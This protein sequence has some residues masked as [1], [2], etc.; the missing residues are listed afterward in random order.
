MPSPIAPPSSPCLPTDAADGAPPPEGL[1]RAAERALGGAAGWTP[2]RGGRSNRLWRVRAPG[3][4]AVVKLY[5]GAP[6]PLFE[7]D[8]AKERAALDALS[9]TGLAPRALASLRTAAGPALIY[10]HVVSGG[11]PPEAEALLRALRAV[12]AV[13]PP[14]GLR[15]AVSGSAALRA[16]LARL[17]AEGAVPPALRRLAARAPDLPPVAAPLFLHGDPTPA[18]ALA[19][20]TGVCLIDWQ[21]PALGDPTDDIALALSP[22][23]R[24]LA[25]LAPLGRAER[26]AAL[27]AYGDAEVAERAEALAPLHAALIAAHCL[28]RAARGDA[29][30]AEAA[31]REL[32]MEG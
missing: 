30:C 2:L 15:R 13:R 11:S 29:A 25:G 31:R 24:R 19:T 5:T 17:A 10:G 8:P 21:C 12:H 9:R 26:T 16:R 6:T 4:E 23:M 20:A 28:W 18:N 32:E 7:N 14:V 1:R 3:G 27:A 22:A